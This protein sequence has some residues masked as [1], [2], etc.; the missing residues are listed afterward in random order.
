MDPTSGEKLLEKVRAFVLELPG[1]ER[2]LFGALIAPG[3]A[4]AYIED[5]VSGFAMTDWSTARL[6]AAL[7]EAIRQSG[8]RVLG[9]EDRT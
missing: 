3:I 2:A 4:Q 6:P 5:E 9:L 7:S 8:I 1:D